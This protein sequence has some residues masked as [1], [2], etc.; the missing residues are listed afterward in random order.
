MA[1]AE[2][3]LAARYNTDNC[4]IVNHYT[5]VIATDG[6]LQEGVSHEACAFAGHNQLDKVI[7]LYDDNNITIDGN[8]DLSFS[9]DVCKRFEAYD[10]HTQKIDGHNYDAIREAIQKA[11]EKDRQAFDH[12][13]QDYHR[14]RKSK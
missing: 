14:L 13:L 5:Y 1:L 11:R 6:D 12:S 3:S 2:A 4:K 10:W 8:T 9:E 7:V